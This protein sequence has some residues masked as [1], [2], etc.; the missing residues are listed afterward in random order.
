MTSKKC[1]TGALR[2]RSWWIRRRPPVAAPHDHPVAL[3]GAAVARRAV[4]VE[5]LLAARHHRSRR[6]RTGNTVASAPFTL[7]VYSSASSR[8]W[9]RATVPVDHRPRRARV[10][11]EGRLAQRDV[12]RLIVHVLAAAPSRTAQMH[13]T[14][15]HRGHRARRGPTRLARA[16]LG[17]PLRSH[18]VS[19]SSPQRSTPPADSSVSRNRRVA[20]RSNF[21]SVA[22][23]HRKNRL[24]LA[25]AKRGTLNTG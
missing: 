17:E 6:P 4:D 21:G 3:A 14:D 13:D 24:R 19:C 11:E 16:S 15:G 7:P 12:L 25:S 9:P 5:A 10:V 1:P 22:S 18:V 8:S 23:M 2:S 20:S